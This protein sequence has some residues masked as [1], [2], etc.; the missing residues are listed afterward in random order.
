MRLAIQVTGKPQPKQRPRRDGRT[1]RWYTPSETI[2]YE[3]HVRACTW[4]ALAMAR[5]R[6]W[7]TDRNYRVTTRIYFPDKRRRDAD[8]VVKAIQDA[9]NGYLWADDAQITRAAQEIEIDRERPRVEVEVEVL[10]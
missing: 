2:A 4:V 7:P 5:I 6:D 8:N 3:K 1:G 9:L 10:P